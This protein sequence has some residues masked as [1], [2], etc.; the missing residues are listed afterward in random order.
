MAKLQLQDGRTIKFPDGLSSEQVQNIVRAASQKSNQAP[1]QTQVQSPPSQPVAPKGETSPVQ[2]AASSGSA[3]PGQTEV[4]LG[5]RLAAAAE[6]ATSNTLRTNPLTGPFVGAYE[7]SKVALGVAQPDTP[8][9][10]AKREA[11]RTAGKIPDDSSAI[12]DIQTGLQ[13][14]PGTMGQDLLQGHK[15]SKAAANMKDDESFSWQ[16]IWKNKKLNAAKAIAEQARLPQ[17]PVNP[18]AAELGRQSQDADLT[19]TLKNYSTALAT[20]PLGVVRTSAFVSLPQSWKS[21]LGGVMGGAVAG[22]RGAAIGAG[23]GSYET[24]FNSRVIEKIRKYGGNTEDEKSILDTIDKYGDKIEAESRNEALTVALFDSIAGVASAKLATAP[25]RGIGGAAVKTVASSAADAGLSAAGEASSQ[26]ITDGDVSSWDSVFQEAMGS[27][28][29]GAVMEGGMLAVDKISSKMKSG[30]MPTEDEMAAAWRETIPEEPISTYT[31]AVNNGRKL[32]AFIKDGETSAVAGS[33]EDAEAR[34]GREGIRSGRLIAVDEASTTEAPGTVSD[35]IMNWA[36]TK[37]QVPGVVKTGFGSSKT[38]DLLEGNKNPETYD[39]VSRELTQIRSLPEDQ[40]KAAV[41]QYVQ[42]N[43]I[44]LLPRQRIYNGDGFGQRIVPRQQNDVLFGS[45]SY[46]LDKAQELAASKGRIIV[47]TATASHIGSTPELEG[48]IDSTFEFASPEVRAEFLNYGVWTRADMMA[49]GKVSWKGRLDPRFFDS[50]VYGREEFITV[51]PGSQAATGQSDAETLSVAEMNTLRT[52]NTQDEFPSHLNMRRQGEYQLDKEVAAF[53]KKSGF[54]TD[55]L[56]GHIKWRDNPLTDRS[57]AIVNSWLRKFKLNKHMLM[58]HIPVSQNSTWLVTTDQLAAQLQASL[59]LNGTVA[60]NMAASISQNLPNGHYNA[61]QWNIAKDLNLLVFQDYGNAPAPRSE[62]AQMETLA[63]E[64]GHAISFAKL[65]GAPL[66]TLL[67]IRAAHR[68][69]RAGFDQDRA[70]WETRA[71]TYWNQGTEMSGQPYSYVSTFEEWW[72]HQFT[73]WAM[74]PGQALGPVTR[75][76]RQV[77]KTIIQFLREAKG[78]GFDT[79]AEPEVI[80][81]LNSMRDGT[82]N[83]RYADS[84]M[85]EVEEQVQQLNAK[86]TGTPL[87]QSVG[88]YENISANLRAIN[89]NIFSNMPFKSPEAQMAQRNLQAASATVDRFGWIY[90]W[91]A[92]LRQL[93]EANPHIR[94]LQIAR[95]LFAQVKI[96]SAKI[97]VSADDILQRWRQLGEKRGKNL[98]QFLF[99]LDQM[100]YRT[101]DEVEK[102]VIRWPTK[103]EFKQ[104]AEDLGLD[105]ETLQVYGEVRDFFLNS[106]RRLEELRLFDAARIV[107]PALREAAIKSAK[108][109]SVQLIKK[110]YFP[111]T[112]FGKYSLTVRK[113]DGTMEG[114]W[115]FET[116]HEAKRA[117]Q[118]LMNDEYPQSDYTTTL[119]TLPEEVAPFVGMS[120]WMLDKIREMPGLSAEQLDWIDQLRYQMAPSQSF[121]KHMMKRKNITGA[122]NDARRVFANYAFHHGKNYARTKYGNAFRDVITSLRKSLPGNY[123]A[124]EISKRN[125]M[126]DMVQHQVN[127]LMNPSRDW[128]HL[129]SLNA[130]WHLGFNVKSAVVNSTQIFVTTAFLGAKFGG[131]KA[132]QAMLSAS[133]RMSSYYRKGSLKQLAQTDSEFRAI[134]RAIKDGHIDESMA[135]E[136]AALAVGGGIGQRIGKSFFGDKFLSGYIAFTEK[137]MWMQRMTDQWQRRLTFRAAWKLAMENPNTKW[138]QELKFKHAVQFEILMKENW[139]EREVLAYLAGYDASTQSQG[140]YDR[141]SRPRYMQG[142]KSVLFAFQ[143]FSQQNLWMLANNKDMWFRYSLYM[144]ALGGMMGLVPDDMENVF[145]LVGKMAFGKDFNLKRGA[146]ELVISMFG[147]KIPPDLI[148][149]GGARYGFGAHAI[150]EMAHAPFIP[151]VDLSSSIGIGRMLPV[152]FAKLGQ[153]GMKPADMLATEAETVAGAA[154]GIPISMFKAIM[155]SEYDV[156][157]FKRWEGAMPA[158]LRNSAR[159]WRYY[160]EGSERTKSGAATLGFDGDD[161]EQLGEIIGLALGF[162]PTRQTQQYD[163]VAAERE[164]DQYWLTQKEMLMR[165]AYRDRFIYKDDEAYTETLKQIREFNL[166]AI[167]PKYK[168][169]GDSLI[170]SFKRRRASTMKIEN[171]GSTPPQVKS[172]VDRLYPETIEEKPVK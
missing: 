29:S 13:I 150:A 157:D 148:L 109:D 62:I 83:V 117:A 28:A 8:E 121:V 11:I 168:I 26:L 57:Q 71:K 144:L 114:F 50:G 95:E 86:S 56:V 81:F 84:L 147:D 79:K 24:E 55:R 167:A 153:P 115:L 166:R 5:S 12:T 143:L 116:A 53:F 113:L 74:E 34:A 130:L 60:R 88:P 77:G 40:R 46:D 23:V 118:S 139:T 87:P 101:A 35:E 43:L 42:N 141:Q 111:Q 73:K 127:E 164:I 85:T 17:L 142:R 126:A 132:E 80:K 39:K 64:F 66:D 67:H 155:A 61:F 1:E 159:A 129:R 97:H 122:S 134:D 93:S 91:A 72:A 20:D 25:L 103:D 33:Y 76:A 119:S 136:L 137:A 151:E 6:N 82:V 63:H 135:A 107:D 52:K 36:L 10:A 98:G 96:E 104:M 7:A 160:Q 37:A 48:L 47:P 30:R 138:L 2:T 125:A 78:K 100:T 49:A 158:A 70:N 165:Q 99:N 45:V 124:P 128:A 3:V 133:T 161:P 9:Q 149:H 22:A 14:M 106:V 65:S 38:W 54:P 156:K 58:I 145:E 108:L 18:V 171:G 27:V 92:N 123:A 90:K 16:E 51:T 154:Y 102:G 31:E 162:R 105:A 32:F 146:R 19:T 69:F 94:E 110:P 4:S 21:I 152:D 172:M 89:R 15:M 59:G 120:P 163:R 112:R 131:L 68:R 140:T 170:T 75:F 44:P 169:T 41:E